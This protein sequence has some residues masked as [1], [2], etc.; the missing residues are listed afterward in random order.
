LSEAFRPFT[1]RSRP[2]RDPPRPREAPSDRSG[3]TD[4]AGRCSSEPGGSGHQ[5][6]RR[7]HLPRPRPRRPVVRRV[8]AAGHHR[9]AEGRVGRTPLGDVDLKAGRVSPRRPR[10]VVNHQVLVSQPKTTKGRRSIALDPATVAAFRDH[11][12]WQLED[13]LAVGP[14]WEDSGL[15]FTWPD[16]RPL[17]QSGSRGG[18]SST[19]PPLG[20]PRSACM[21]SGTA[22]P[23]PRWRLGSRPR[24]S[25]S[26]S[27]TPTSPSPWTPI[28][29]CCPAWTSRRP[30]RSPSSSSASH[31][32]RSPPMTSADTRPSG[33]PQARGG[34]GRTAWSAV[35]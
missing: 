4:P 8:V 17:H 16:G 12:H 10:V 23:P 6:G 28:A 33:R 11:R 29:T 21:T 19:P 24:S 13:R 26:A 7:V 15:V 32:T 3:W 34:E 22:T 27:G 30:A 35:G 1:A 14:R 2:Q 25:A 31:A 5:L 18:S 9:H 20:S